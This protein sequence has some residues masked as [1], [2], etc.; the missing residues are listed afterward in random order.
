M[1][2]IE[3]TPNKDHP[4]TY[5]YNWNGRDINTVYNL[6]QIMNAVIHSA[7]LRP[8]EL[9]QTLYEEKGNDAWNYIRDRP[10][11]QILAVIHDATRISL[12]EVEGVETAEVT[13]EMDGN[14]GVHIS[15]TITT[16]NG[17]ELEVEISG[18]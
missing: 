11:S 10:T 9:L 13:T 16:T 2:D 14:Y 17:T 5:D 15:S 18:S 8:G 4:G 7:L 1:K 6:E 3:L 12:E